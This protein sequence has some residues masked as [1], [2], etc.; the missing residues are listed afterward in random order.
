MDVTQIPFVA[1]VG[2]T[3]NAQGLLEL[4]FASSLENHLSSLHASAQFTLA[5]TASGD[6]LQSELP[7]LVDH[8]VPLLRESTLKFK[9]PA[10]QT[11]IAYPEIATEQVHKFR[12]QFDTK[13]RATLLVEVAVKDSEGNITCSGKFNWFLQRI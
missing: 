9:K 3:R 1:H 13:G 12:S 2:I 7:E 10:N 8:V 11:V 6:I 4:P 5:E